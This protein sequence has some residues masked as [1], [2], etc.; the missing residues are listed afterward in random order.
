M[1]YAM[2][3][4]MAQLSV[5]GALRM[6]LKRFWTA[7]VV[8][9]G[10]MAGPMADRTHALSGQEYLGLDYTNRAIHVMGMIEAMKYADDL[11]GTESFAWLFQCVGGWTGAQLEAVFTSYLETHPQSM[12]YRSP[13][14]LVSAAGNQCPDA[15]M[16]A[17]N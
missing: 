16:W 15:P 11:S 8:M 1:A 17:K 2:C 4:A 14:L 9:G 6:V 5:N 12:Q 7:I 10:L 3:Q 13:G